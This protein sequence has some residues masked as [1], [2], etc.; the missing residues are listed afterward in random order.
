MLRTLGSPSTPS[1]NALICAD[2]PRVIPRTRAGANTDA[3][4]GSADIIGGMSGM[5]GSGQRRAWSDIR[6]G[7]FTPEPLDDMDEHWIEVTETSEMMCDSCRNFPPGDIRMNN[8]TENRSFCLNCASN[9]TKIG[10]YETEGI[11][12]DEHAQDAKGAARLLN[13][14]N[15]CISWREI[16]AETN[17]KRFLVTA[18]LAMPSGFQT[19]NDVLKRSHTGEP[20]ACPRTW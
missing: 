2:H 20:F 8:N 4:T 17:L 1:N 6:R 9:W 15:N 3:Q 5:E 11:H 10:M 18:S 16:H 13:M 12:V 19:T 14:Y 7:V